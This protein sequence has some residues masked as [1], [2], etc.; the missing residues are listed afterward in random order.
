MNVK[1]GLLVASEP[2]LDEL[3]KLRLPPALLFTVTKAVKA[4]GPHLAEYDR[5]WRQRVV[6]LG[7]PTYDPA[8]LDEEG[9]PHPDAQPTGHKVR[10]ENM[11]TYNKEIAALRD[12]DV[13][14]PGIGPIKIQHFQDAADRYGEQ[15]FI[16]G[17]AIAILSEWLLTE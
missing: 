9:R 13:E 10:D 16:S 3:A 4:V 17:P 7:E 6:E 2:A 12:Q 15:T 1:L 14:L 8:V 5:I 11:E